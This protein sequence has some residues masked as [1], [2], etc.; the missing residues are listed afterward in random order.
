[1]LNNFAPTLVKLVFAAALMAVIALPAPVQAQSGSEGSGKR[2]AVDFWIEDCQDKASSSR[3]AALAYS[4]IGV[5]F[6][7]TNNNL[8]AAEDRA[9]SKCDKL[10]PRSMRKKAPCRIVASADEI[11]NEGYLRLLQQDI[12]M[13]VGLEIYDGESTKLQRVSGFM[14]FGESRST[15]AHTL[16]IQLENG[17]PLC[18]GTY[19]VSKRRVSFDMRCFG[20]FRFKD[21]K[22]KTLG[23]FL[24][25]GIYAPVFSA[26]LTR[27][28]S[29]IKISPPDPD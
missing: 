24:S 28:D 5:Q 18:N 1:M 20:K 10:V 21:Q 27:N 26:E 9:L 6:C 29:Y 23:Y 19:Q 13:P 14:V 11:V 16:Q 8:R 22:A 15:E 2:Y 25:N 3:H 17:A 12:K 4:K 7:S